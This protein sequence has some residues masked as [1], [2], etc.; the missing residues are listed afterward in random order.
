MQI[1][2]AVQLVLAGFFVGAVV[3][4]FS[5]AIA[6]AIVG[7]ISH[8]YAPDPFVDAV[9]FI[10]FVVILMFGV[11]GFGGGALM[12]EKYGSSWETV[13]LYFA[14]AFASLSTLESA[15]GASATLYW[16]TVTGL[17]LLATLA[18]TMGMGLIFRKLS[19]FVFGDY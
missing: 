19:A 1:P 5:V 15:S 14:G 10:V 18:C 12:S 6:A 17:S 8:K 16:S 13:P 9:G 4:T 2:K 7:R 11:F 3:A